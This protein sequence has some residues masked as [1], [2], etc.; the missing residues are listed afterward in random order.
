MIVKIKVV[1]VDMLVQMDPGKYVPNV[2]YGKGEKVLYI[3]IIKDIY[4]VLR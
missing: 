3:K 1:P 2:I 4:G